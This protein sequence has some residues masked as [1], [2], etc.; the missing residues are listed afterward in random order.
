[1]RKNGYT[2]IEV[3]V[4]LTIFTVVIAAPTGFFVSALKGQQ[5]VLASQ[6]VYDNISYTLEYIS[7]ALRMARKDLTGSCIT[8]NMN[9]VTTADGNG[10]K[11]K[12]YDGDCQEFY[13]DI[14]DNRLK[15]TSDAKGVGIPLTARNI[16]VVSFTIEGEGTWSQ[17][18]GF[19]P[20]ITLL[21]EIK[22]KRGALPELQPIMKIQTSVSQRQLD[23]GY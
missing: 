19:Q 8:E 11:F 6:E 21:L 20:K 7:R 4:A 17:D 12:N 3:L 15:E 23:I 22:G 5:K 13:L 16:E 14:E 2:L 10:I 18:D 1:M 9:Y